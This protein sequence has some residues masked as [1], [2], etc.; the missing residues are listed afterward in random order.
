MIVIG[1]NEGI[2]ASVAVGRDGE[3]VFALQEERLSRVKNHMGFPHKALDAALAFLQLAP[4]DVD[5]VCLSNRHSPE[6][7]KEQ[8]YRQCETAAKDT[9][10]LV[11]DREFE[12]LAYLGY[13]HLP[14]RWRERVKTTLLDPVFSRRNRNQEAHIAAHG[15]GRARLHRF[16]HHGNHAASAYYGLCRDFDAPHLIVTLDGGGDDSCGHVYIGEKGRLRL[17]AATPSGNSP[18]QIYSNVTYFM[19]MTPHE[20]EYKLMGLAPYPHEK[21]A[22]GLADIFRSYLDL[23]PENP[24]RFKRKIP[25][26]THRLVPR[27]FKDFRRVRFDNL[28]AGL[29]AFT[30]DLLARWLTALMEKTGIRRVLAAGGVF[31]NVKANKR[32]AELPGI[33]SFD[34]FPSCGDETLPFGAV[35]QTEVADGRAPDDRFRL[36]HFHLGPQAGDDLEA[37]LAGHEG[38]LAVRRL[39]DPEARTAE[40]LHKGRIVARCSG[41]MEFGAR[42]LGNRSILADPA[43]LRVIAVINRMIKQRDFWMP[44]A[45]AM[46]R[47]QAERF[48]RIPASL[49]GDTVSPYMMQTFDTTELRDVFL[50][51]V[52]SA[53]HTARAQI[54][55]E[56][57]NPAF[58]R[59]VGRFAELSGYGVVLN[60]SFNLHGFPIVTGAR[61]A[62]DVL[63]RSGLD[64]LVVDDTLIEKRPDAR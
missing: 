20:H 12:A 40:L 44:F 22:R 61:D 27:L 14:P 43:N 60:T 33:E 25:E 11:R 51:G 19:G 17:L 2:N 35:W 24:L 50:A 3:I 31:M 39:D 5:A 30:E 26:P 1:I 36:R 53:D 21:Y 49:P 4:G 38:E 54:V 15:L 45:P 13:S 28:S 16:D 57:S 29:Q 7:T 52:H 32:I 34:V 6:V 56:T 46:L 64:C 23:D 9:W 18:G 41:R 10:Q 55:T 62:V 8:F 37:A 58:H 42:A 48:I 63:L 47:E 59:L